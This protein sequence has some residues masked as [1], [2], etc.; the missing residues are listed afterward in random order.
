MERMSS[1]WENGQEG[2]KRQQGEYV[3]Q[4]GGGIMQKK[5]IFNQ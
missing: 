1:A 5:E 4:G 2:V 3:G